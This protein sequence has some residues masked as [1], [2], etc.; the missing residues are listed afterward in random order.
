MQSSTFRL[1]LPMRTFMLLMGMLVVATILGPLVVDFPHLLIRT[2]Q[3][4]SWIS[5]VFLL[6]VMLPIT[7]LLSV[8]SLFIK[9][10]LSAN[11]IEYY[12][13]CGVVKV[14]WA[15]ILNLEAIVQGKDNTLA[16]RAI[17]IDARKWVKAIP[18]QAVQKRLL[19]NTVKAGIPLG[20][21]SNMSQVRRDIGSWSK[22]VSPQ[23]PNPDSFKPAPNDKPS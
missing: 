22:E 11:G 5:L 13:L 2:L 4:T 9:V 20:L 12:A 23:G 10:V 17:T 14:Q 19:L 1:S 3:T 21:L 6:F 8:S 7:V 15:D 16:V 18:W